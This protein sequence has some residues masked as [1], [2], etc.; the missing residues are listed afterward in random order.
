MDASS[1]LSV[2]T[3]SPLNAIQGMRAGDAARLSAK[4][5]GYDVN[6]PYNVSSIT[7]QVER[8]LKSKGINADPM[9]VRA[10]AEMVRK[11]GGLIEKATDP[12]QL[13][14]P[15]A[16]PADFAGQY[17]QPL[18]PTE[19]LAMCEEISTLIL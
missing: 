14:S 10:M 13:P 2:P 8:E 12:T 18:D 4:S 5:A 17:P 9:L 7:E 19:I 6:D 15:Y 16:S 1:L 3:L 11:S